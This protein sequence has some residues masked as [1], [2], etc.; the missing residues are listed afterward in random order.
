MK[1]LILII[2][3]LSVSISSA[4]TTDW[5]ELSKSD[6]YEI[7][8]D[9]ESHGEEDLPNKSVVIN[10]LDDTKKN[11]DLLAYRDLTLAKFESEVDRESIDQSPYSTYGDK[12]ILSFY[13]LTDA[14]QKILGAYIYLYQDG[15]DEDGNEGDIN[16]GASARFDHNGDF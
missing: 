16:W 9:L 2:L 4:M 15:R 7:L 14:H 11:S 1:T 5:S 3:T 8:L 12:R 6:Q 10:M 13:I